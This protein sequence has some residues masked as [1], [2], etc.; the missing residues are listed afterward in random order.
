MRDDTL[1]NHSTYL[2][3]PRSWLGEQFYIEAEELKKRKRIAYRHE[4]LGEA[5][6]TGGK[7]FDNV[8]IREITDAEIAIF[9]KLKQGLDF[10][11]AADPLAFER[12]HLNKKQR[13]LY[14]FAE[15]YQV[16]LK[17]RK[18]VEEIKKLNP[19]NKIITADSEEPRSIGSLSDRWSGCIGYHHAPEAHP[20]SPMN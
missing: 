16:N 11:F 13:R 19:E 10:G 12:M 9:D 18:A 4:Y 20:D 7:V 15:L 5:T 6:G 14:I 2:T 8:I 3:V 1:C 17:T